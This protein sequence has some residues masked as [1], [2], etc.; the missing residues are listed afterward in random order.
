[1]RDEEKFPTVRF[2]KC[3]ACAHV[4]TASLTGE[5]IC[6][7]CNIPAYPEIKDP[8]VL[9][10]SQGGHVL[11]TILGP[12]Y[13]IKELEQLKG[14]I[15]ASLGEEVDSLAFAF[16]NTSYLDSSTLN[17]LVKAMHSLSLRNKPTYVITDDP[18]VLESM[19]MVDLDKVLTVLPSLERYREA[20]E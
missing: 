9:K 18:H 19:Q 20:L 15:E 10:E 5:N 16:D 1:L 17:L 7:R 14:Q 12:L 2:L 13:K 11:F 6:P 4:Y 8:R 3:Q